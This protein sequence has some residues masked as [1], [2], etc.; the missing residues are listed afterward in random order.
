MPDGRLSNSLKGSLLPVSARDAAQP[1]SILVL[2]H[3][4]E[5]PRKCSLS[6]LRARAGAGLGAVEFVRVCPG[7][8]PPALGIRGVA[9]KV[10]APVLSA[11]DRERL[12]IDNDAGAAAEAEGRRPGRLV[13]IDGNWAK[14]SYILGH[15]KAAPGRLD[16]RSLPASLRT[17]YPRRSK[18]RADPASGL[19]SIEAL[20]AA[21]RILGAPMDEVTG[22][23][24]GYPWR[25]GFLDLNREFF[26]A[27]QS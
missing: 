6:P 26:A 21:L 8:L 11:S 19:A 12:A 22:I 2:Q 5:N 10:D 25:D 3:H 7:A 27:A 16:F 1:I 13:L 15:L 20:A 14:I 24:E 23:L 18:L 9:L 4:R 17:A